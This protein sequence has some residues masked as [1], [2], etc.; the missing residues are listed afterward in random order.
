MR[1]PNMPAYASAAEP[2][3]GQR[4]AI[5]GA[6]WAFIVSIGFWIGIILFLAV[7]INLVSGSLVILI[8]GRHL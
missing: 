6:L 2:T 5:L 7:A 1:R 8:I 3:P 4:W